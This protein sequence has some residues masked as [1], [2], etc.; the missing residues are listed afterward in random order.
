MGDT[1]AAAHQGKPLYNISPERANRQFDINI[2]PK[3]TNRDSAVSCLAAKFDSMH[4]QGKTLERK[5][6]D[7]AL[8]RAMLG[9]EE[10]E[11]EMRRYREEARSLRKQVDD[12]GVKCVKWEE[13]F[14]GV[15]V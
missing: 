11:G 10:A 2:S 5:T 1:L 14:S 12:L 4:F 8:K 6:N 7:A 15:Q 3:S 13:R 9:R